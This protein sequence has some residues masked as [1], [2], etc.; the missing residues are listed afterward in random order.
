MC[1]GMSEAIQKKAWD[2]TTRWFHWINVLCVVGLIGAGLVILYAGELGI[3]NDGKIAL[4]SIH[5]SIG[6][7]FVANL[8]WRFLW[9]F[10]G[11]PRAR[12]SAFLPGGRG[13]GKALAEEWQS[14]R[15]RDS[16]HYLGHTPFGRLSVTV[17]M[18]LLACQAVTGIVL[19][20][21]DLYWPPFGGWIAAWVA[22]PGVDPSVLVPYHDTHLDAAAYEAMRAFRAPVLSV[23][24]W[25]FFALCAAII[26]H[27]AAVVVAEV[28]TRDGLVSAMFSGHK[29][30]GGTPRD[31]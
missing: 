12:W 11:S 20:G 10:F 19:A 24:Y 14:L 28:R 27:I 30:L 31:E 4:K 17:L 7:V 8:V 18:L 26:V 22:S 15:T 9:A 23:H 13:Y 2:R 5:V 25:T 1:E 16:G 3:G 29:T 21:T 6:Y